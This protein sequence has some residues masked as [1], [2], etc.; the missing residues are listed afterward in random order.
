M[1]EHDDPATFSSLDAHMRL[2]DY[3]NDALGQKFVRGLNES[4]L[5]LETSLD[6][7]ISSKTYAPINIVGVPRSGT[8]LISQ[9]LVSRFDLGFVSNLMARFYRVP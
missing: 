7:E 4:L 8:T 9:L 3:A 5:E 2:P 1:P 6:S